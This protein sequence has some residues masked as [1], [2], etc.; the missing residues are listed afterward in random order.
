[1]KLANLIF[2]RKAIIWLADNIGAVFF[3]LGFGAALWAGVLL[4]KGILLAAALMAW[5]ALSLLVSGMKE[6][7]EAH[8]K[9]V[10]DAVKAK[11]VDQTYEKFK[12]MYDKEMNRNRSN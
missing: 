10:E 7:A 11:L 12:E 6:Y 8:V 2:F 9:K 5:L 4:N 1:M 3:G